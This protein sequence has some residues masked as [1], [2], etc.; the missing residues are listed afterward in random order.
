MQLSAGIGVLITRG[1]D[2]R[3]KGIVIVRRP[4]DRIYTRL[5]Q[6]H[7]KIFR[8]TGEKWCHY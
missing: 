4:T 2:I 7:M 1:P 6:M 8:L 5:A 3:V